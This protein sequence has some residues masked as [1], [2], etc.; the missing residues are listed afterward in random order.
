[1]STSS[2]LSLLANPQYG[3]HLVCHTGLSLVHCSYLSVGSLQKV[4]HARL[5]EM[6]DGVMG[7]NR[8]DLGTSE[9]K[10]LERLMRRYVMV[11]AAEPRLVFREK[12]G[13]L[14][15]W[16]LE[17]DVVR[18]LA[19]LHEGHGHFANNITLARAHGRV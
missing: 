1:M 10:L 17:E 9:R 14:A 5:D 11:E 15:T 6:D 2:I 8:M 18:R 16:V 3:Y 19:N 13:E 12:D 7:V 4:V